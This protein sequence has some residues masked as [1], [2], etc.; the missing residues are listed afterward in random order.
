VV[1]LGFNYWMDEPRAALLSSRLSRLEEDIAERRRLTM[2]YRELLGE[3]P[4]VGVPYSDEQ[5][6]ASACYVMAVM[7]DEPD[8]RDRLQTILSER[9]GV[10]TTVLYASISEFTAYAGLVPEPLGRCEYA[11][12]AQFTLP[13]YPHLG[14][15]RLLRVV[16]ALRES[17]DELDS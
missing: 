12:R 3:I 1:D 14:E 17:L 15:E 10:Q 11:A 8:I 4:G 13:L 16:N 6:A 5:V 7:L 9:H 2:R